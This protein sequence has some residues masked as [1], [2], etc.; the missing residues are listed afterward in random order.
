MKGQCFIVIKGL[1]WVETSVFCHKK[2]VIFKLENEDGYH[3]FQW[4]REPDTKHVKVTDD[5]VCM[6]VSFSETNGEMNKWVHDFA[7]SLLVEQGAPCIVNKCIKC[8]RYFWFKFTKTSITFLILNM[9]KNCKKH[10]IHNDVLYHTS[11]MAIIVITGID[12]TEKWSQT[13]EHAT[14]MTGGVAYFCLNMPT[15]YQNGGHRNKVFIYQK[16]STILFLSKI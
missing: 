8:M 10:D 2:G 4:V 5:T 1:F 15:R 11:D 7:M 9:L 14:C 6:A 13:R 12:S 16:H 3:F